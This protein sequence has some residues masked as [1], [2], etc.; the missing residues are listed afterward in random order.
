M[1]DHVKRRHPDLEL[2][3]AMSLI[4]GDQS[5]VESQKSGE[6]TVGIDL[7]LLDLDRALVSE[8]IRGASGIVRSDFC[9]MMPP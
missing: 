2:A 6:V 3:A 7:D 4:I 9:Q 1:A 8:N 5:L